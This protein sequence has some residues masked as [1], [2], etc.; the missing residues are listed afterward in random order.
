MKLVCKAIFLKKLQLLLSKDLLQTQGMAVEKQIRQAR[1]KKWNGYAKSPFGSVA[2]VVEY[3]GRYTHKRAI[4]KHHILSIT[5]HSVT[6]K[7]KDYRDVKKRCHF[8]S[9][10]F[11]AGLNFIFYRG[12]L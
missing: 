1:F 8:P 3:L 11:C 9:L 4:T 10:S 12:A 6:F 2:S 5:E 7:Y